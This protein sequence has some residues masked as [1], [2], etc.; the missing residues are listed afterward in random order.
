ML[1]RPDASMVIDARVD[2]ETD[3]GALIHMT[4][5]GRAVFPPHVLSQARD[6]E[7]RGGIDQGDYYMRTTPAFETGSARHLWLNDVVC[8]GVGR[9][10]TEGLAYDVFQVA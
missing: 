6:A 2:L 4:Y 8:V 1:I 5:G 7:A 9:L 3:D 10:T